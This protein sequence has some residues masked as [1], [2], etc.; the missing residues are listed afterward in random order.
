MMTEKEFKETVYREFTSENV[1]RNKNIIKGT[2]AKIDGL[3]KVSVEG[4]S[5]HDVKVVIEKDENDMIKEI[6]FYCSC[7]QTKS[8]VLDYSD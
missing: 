1:S 6:K 5:L 8:V 4:E 3:K 7:G 2:N